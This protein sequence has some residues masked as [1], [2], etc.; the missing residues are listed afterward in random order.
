MSVIT[1]IAIYV[2]IWWVILFAILPIGIST[3]EEQGEVA[4]GTVSSAPHRPRIGLKL[5]ATTIAAGVIFAI[6]WGLQ[7]VGY[8]LDDIPFLPRF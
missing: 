5:I 7:G 2:V 3:Q 4:P 6:F 1:A 8:T